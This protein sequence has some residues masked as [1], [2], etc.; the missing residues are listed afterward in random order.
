L[1]FSLTSARQLP[2]TPEEVNLLRPRGLPGVELWTIRRSLRPWTAFHTTYVFCT[3]AGLE[4]EQSW[5]CRGAVHKLSPTTTILFEPGELH[6]ATEIKTPSDLH[7]LLVA[8]ELLERGRHGGIRRFD[9]LGPLGQVGQLASHLML[10]AIEP[11]DDPGGRAWP[12]FSRPQIEDAG[13][14]GA[15]G[16]LCRA[17]EG[18]DADSLEQQHYFEV[19]LRALL[20]RAAVGPEEAPPPNRCDVALSRVRAIIES[21]F[22]SRLTLDDLAL[23]T[24]FSKYYLERSFNDRYGLPI[25]QFLMKVRIARALAMLRGGTRPAEVAFAVGFSDQP[26][27]TRVFR[28]ELGFTPRQ[29]WAAARP[30]APS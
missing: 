12:R 10:D 26:H 15:F 30:F 27:L 14:V 9:R 2:G 22:A 3:P 5:R 4:G 16:R 1:V 8:P 28:N 19:Y 23:Q 18:P 20:E 6:V 13:L 21:R 7:F 17:L 25:H 24:G 11:V 29:Y